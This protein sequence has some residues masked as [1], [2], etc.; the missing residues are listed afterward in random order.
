M[1]CLK[2]CLD[3]NNYICKVTSLNLGRCDLHEQG[4][5]RES[6]GALWGNTHPLM[7][8]SKMHGHTANQVMGGLHRC[9][10]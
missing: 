8:H 2:L 9:V 6:R 1:C 10:V 4:R 3:V 7:S 5:A